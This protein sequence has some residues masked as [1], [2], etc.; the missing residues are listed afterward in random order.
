MENHQKNI[1]IKSEIGYMKKAMYGKVVLGTIFNFW[2]MFKSLMFS[3][4]GGNKW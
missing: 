3:Q 2:G 4:I 1:K